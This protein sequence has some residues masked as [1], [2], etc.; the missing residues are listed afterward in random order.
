M[1]EVARKKLRLG[2][3]VAA[4]HRPFPVQGVI[5]QGVDASGGVRMAQRLDFCFRQLSFSPESPQSNFRDLVLEPELSYLLSI[6]V[7]CLDSV[8]FMNTFVI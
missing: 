6:T 7:L 5:E 8:Q 3:V 4:G 1:S 2:K